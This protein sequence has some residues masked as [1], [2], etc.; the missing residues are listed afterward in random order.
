[1]EMERKSNNNNN[2]NNSNRSIQET[3]PLLDEPA[4]A[5]VGIFTGFKNFLEKGNVLQLGVAFVLGV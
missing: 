3:D 2:N 5:K 4:P 1:M